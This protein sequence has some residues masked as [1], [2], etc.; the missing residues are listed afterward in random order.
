M[1]EKRT[2]TKK[3][4]TPL[5][6]NEGKS[7]KNEKI[8]KVCKNSLS[9]SDFDI[10]N[11][12]PNDGTKILFFV[13]LL[14]GIKFFIPLC[15]TNLIL[16]IPYV[17]Y[18]FYLL[19]RYNFKLVSVASL[20]VVC[21]RG[22]FNINN[23]SYT[24]IIVIST[25]LLYS[26]AFDT[27]VK[28]LKFNHLPS[29]LGRVLW[30]IF[31]LC[32]FVGSSAVPIYAHAIGDQY[33]EPEV[34][35]PIIYLYP[36]NTQEININLGHKEKISH[37]Y[38][39]YE[40]GWTVKAKPNGDLTYRGREYY[41]LYW[42]GKKTPQ[43]DMDVGF[44]IKGSESAKFLEEKLAILGL[45]ER[46]ANEFIIYWL[47]RLENNPYNFIKFASIEKQN[48]YMPL[49]IE[50]KPDMVIRIMMAFKGL[51]EP[52]NVKEQVL[53]KVSPRSGFVAV[54]WGGTEISSN[55]LY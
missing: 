16:F 32:S 9:I 3:A 34:M 24:I 8:E 42:E 52:I 55:I 31:I 19:I 40:D 14:F 29:V 43:F 48:D 13:V 27:T 22:I 4:K 18:L 49:N 26:L 12:L 20:L 47:P 54:E 6:R 30:S 23:W 45:N 17:I 5:K 33:M 28:K 25:E 2:S 44:V 46:E 50:P 41:G 15:E 38:P 21:I 10:I 37:S 51:K 39:K 7:V 53:K 11:I 35:K 36:E 1:T